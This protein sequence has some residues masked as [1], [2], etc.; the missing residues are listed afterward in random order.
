MLAIVGLPATKDPVKTLV[1]LKVH[2]GDKIMDLYRTGLSQL[3]PLFCSYSWWKV[4]SAILIQYTFCQVQQIATLA[5]CSM[6]SLIK[7]LV[8]IL[9]IP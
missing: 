9:A 5:I 3:H 8:F 7:T 2:R 4:L 1:R 6:C